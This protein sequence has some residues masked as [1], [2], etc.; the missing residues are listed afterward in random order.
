MG[1]EHYPA[2][3]A[4]CVLNPKVARFF[5]EFLPPFV[6]PTTGGLVSL[7]MLG[8]TFFTPGTFYSLALVVASAGVTGFLR[9]RPGATGGVRHTLS[10]GVEF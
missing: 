7:R 3:L 8:L 1:I 5:L 6:D 4:A 10:L 2:F 9:R